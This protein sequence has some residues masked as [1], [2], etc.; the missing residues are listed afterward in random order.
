[1]ISQNTFHSTVFIRA[2]GNAEIGLGHVM[3]SLAFAKH[4]MSYS[5]V[6]LMIRN[7]DSVVI[8]A[9][10]YYQIPVHD[11]SHI[12][13]KKE[14][15]YIAQIAGKRSVVFLDGYDFDEDY[16]R[17][18][19]E[20]GCFLVCMDDH[21]NRFFLADCIINI[22]ELE[23]NE[24]VKRRVGSRLVYGLKYS[25]L[26]PEFQPVKGSVTPQNETVF[27]CF[28]GGEETISLIQK[29]VEAIAYSNIETTEI[30]V[31]LNSGFLAEMEAWSSVHFPLLPLKYFVNLSAHDMAALIGNSSLGITSASTISLE[32]R[33]MGL[34]LIAGYYT[35]NQ[36]ALYKSLKQ[37][38][39]IIGA[40]DFKNIS[41]EALAAL[42]NQEWSK[43]FVATQSLL[44][45][46][47]LGLQYAKLIQS[48]FVEMEFSMRLAT[49][50]DSE[51]YLIWA[52][53]PDVRR[54]AIQTAQILSDDHHRW[55]QNRLKDP[56]TFL[57]VGFW[58]N[59][60]IGQVRFDLHDA[61]F[62]IDYSVDEAFRG[63]GFGEML[64]RH[65]MEAIGI[66]EK[67]DLRVV[68]L[69]RPENIASCEVFRKLGFVEETPELR[70]GLILHR[71]VYS[72]IS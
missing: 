55:F 14:A 41:A 18:I 62:E 60:P 17:K 5:S 32:C 11:I 3:R 40:G 58:K 29:T 38:Q 35:D 45:P 63:K 49:S 27:I 44:N 9:Y 20:S 13:L 61:T 64:I 69:V 48:W 43:Q 4:A 30:R 1:M 21:H 47:K 39:E 54:N 50:A 52:N 37:E 19:K 31:V 36:H 71:F 59:Q 28:G 22:A 56:D 7:P 23:K 46:E 26:R 57:F 68:G 42:I 15:E 10:K 72:P 25:L 12:P 66:S 33:A 65:G 51:Q 53:H 67:K 34:P 70:S 6:Q 16:Q 24:S 8:E 2:D